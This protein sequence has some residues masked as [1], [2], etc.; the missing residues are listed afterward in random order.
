VLDRI[1]FPINFWVRCPCR[2]WKFGRFTLL[3]FCYYSALVAGLYEFSSRIRDLH[4]PWAEDGT[5]LLLYALERRFDIFHPVVD[6]ICL[7]PR[8]IASVAVSIDLLHAPLICS[9][10]SLVSLAFLGCYITSEGFSWIIPDRWLRAMIGVVFCFGPGSYEIAGNCICISY[11]VVLIL[12]LLSLHHN[13]LDSPKSWAV[14]AICTLSTSISFV[15]VPILAV[16]FWYERKRTF[17]GAAAFSVVVTSLDLFIASGTE[18]AQSQ[19]SITSL[20]DLFSPI[21]GNVVEY[22][23]LVPLVGIRILQKLSLD[24][25]APPVLCFSVVVAALLFKGAGQIDRRVLML[26][27]AMFSSVALY[28]TAHQIS[29]PYHVNHV[30]LSEIPS[31]GRAY[32]ITLLMPLMGWA[33]L[34]CQRTT[35][36]FRVRVGLVGALAGI[37]VLPQMLIFRD[38][39]PVVGEPRWETFVKGISSTTFTEVE[40]VTIELAVDPLGW[41]AVVC[42]AEPPTNLFCSVIGGNGDGATYLLDRSNLT[43][44]RWYIFNQPIK[45]AAQLSSIEDMGKRLS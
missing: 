44:R 42:K 34:L 33:M 28:L 3:M 20:W 19:L 5:S 38:A 7:L 26:C 37:H 35:A 31:T 40:G 11:Q 14:W 10:I 32:L 25:L 15:T 9:Y 21:L 39:T 18:S 45:P 17:V 22:C 12:I 30:L 41:G 16:R 4:N 2:R 24:V 27:F 29:R 36:F 23:L 8:F 13:S 6:G 43:V 1:V